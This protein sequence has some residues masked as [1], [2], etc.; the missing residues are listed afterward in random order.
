MPATITTNNSLRAHQLAMLGMLRALDAVCRAE[1]IRYML[2]AGT[3][4][5]FV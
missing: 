5:E 4:L 3:A 2:F 1:G